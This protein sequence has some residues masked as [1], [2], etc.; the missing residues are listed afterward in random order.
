M[1][2][3]TVA[4]VMARHLVTMVP[5]TTFKELVGTM[6]SHDLDALPVID[7][8]GRPAGVVED[9]DVLA[10]LEFRGGA[11]H[12]PLL[13]YRRRARWHKSSGLT[14]ADLMTAPRTIAQHSPLAA[15]VQTLTR[16][17]I[18]ALCVV[19]TTGRLVGTLSRRDAVRL[20]L[21][22]DGPIRADLEREIA[23][24]TERAGAVSAHVAG[25]VVTLEGTLIL[26]SAVENL[27]Q[28]A[29]RVPGVIAVRNYVRY[30]VDDLVITGL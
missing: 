23:A 4:D 27:C 7:L 16:E 21:R 8:S 15:A 25:G 14:A 18:R 3:P 6:I 2:E 17:Q 22:G 11:D 9:V 1:N 19:D 30:E 5:S 10:K 12:P 26:R 28:A 24:V 13:A 20:F 29:H